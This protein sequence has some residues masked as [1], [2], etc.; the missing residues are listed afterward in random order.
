[1]AKWRAIERDISTSG[2]VNRLDEFGQLLWDRMI[3]WSDDWGII[4]GEAFELKLKTMP[5]S[6]REEQEF[7][8]AV[9]QMEQ[10]GLVRRYQPN[11]YEPLIWLIDFDDHQPAAVIG[12]RTAPKDPLHPDDGRLHETPGNSTKRDEKGAQSRIDKNRVEENRGSTADK[13]FSQIF[14]EVTGVLIAT[15]AQAEKIDAWME[16]ISEDWFRDACEEAVDNNV[17][18]WVYIEA[19]LERWSKEGK[20]KRGSYKRSR[21]TDDLPYNQI[22]AERQAARE[23]A[24]LD[25]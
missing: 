9:N 10:L 17:R 23:A 21:A 13:P 19:I 25:A 24:E 11:A 4:T 5:A 22:A 2:K 8:D 20:Q 15:P 16:D 6:K 7:E 1:M 3:L 12:K 18:K 14:T